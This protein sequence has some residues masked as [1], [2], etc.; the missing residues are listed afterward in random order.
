M[1]NDENKWAWMRESESS[2]YFL[3]LG[4]MITQHVGGIYNRYIWL[5]RK[6]Y[7]IIIFYEYTNF[8]FFPP[9]KIILLCIQCV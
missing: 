7:V 2:S 6:I 4:R 1:L 5:G 9:M 8:M 3:F